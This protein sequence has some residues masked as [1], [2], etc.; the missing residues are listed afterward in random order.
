VTGGLPYH[1]GPGNNYA[2]HSIVAIVEKLRL[3]H[4]RDTIGCVGAN[5]GKYFKRKRERVHRVYEKHL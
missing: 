1:G 2:S 4:Y 5:G 3:A